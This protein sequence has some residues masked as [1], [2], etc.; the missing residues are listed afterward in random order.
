MES[1][2][3]TLRT[4]G[5]ISFTASI[6]VGFVMLVL[7][8]WANFEAYFFFGY[9]APADTTLTT[10]KCPLLM[11]TADTGNISIRLT[12]TTSLDL[13]PMIRTEISYYGAARSD[14]NNYPLAAGETRNFSWMVSPDDMVFGHLI[15]ARVY[16]YSAYTLPSRDNTCGIVVVNLPG[17]TGIQLFVILIAFILVCMAAGWGLWLAG[18]HPLQAPGRIA[19]TAMAIF[20]GVVLIGILAGCMDWWGVGLI[21][22][23]ICV[24]LTI[25]VVGN[26]I[27]KA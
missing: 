4:L 12:N 27:Q 26:Y 20:T 18:S 23:V 13:S 24:L 2:K 15:L 14:S 5:I 25:A 6:L 10:L 19:L 7:M 16:V 21:C 9:T 17:L 3:K 11:T 8:N 22:T 1:K